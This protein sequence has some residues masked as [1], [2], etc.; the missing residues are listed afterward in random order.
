MIV[1]LQALI[2]L[3]ALYGA[4]VVTARLAFPLPRLSA[5]RKSE[6]IPMSEETTLGRL[7]AQGLADN[8][9]KSGVLGIPEGRGA[10]A[11]RLELARQA[12]ASIDAQY[13]IWEDDTSGRLLMKALFDAAQR[14]VRVRMLLDDN[15]T[16]GLDAV[17]AALDG[18]ENF[19]VRLFNPS[20]LRWPKGAGFV[21]DFVR[22]NRRMHNKAFIVDGAVAIVGGRNVADEYFQLADEGFFIDLDVLA[23]GAVAPETAAIFDLYWNCD[24]VHPAGPVIGRRDATLPGWLTG[25]E[26]IGP[27]AESL[28]MSEREGTAADRFL[29]GDTRLEWVNAQAIAD[30]PSKGLG[31]ASDGQLMITRLRAAAG[32]VTSGVDLVSAYFIPAVGGVRYFAELARKGA[33]VRILTNAFRTTDVKMVHAGYAKYR[34]RLLAAGVELLELKPGSDGD[35]VSRRRSG[36]GPSSGST[37][38]T[39]LHAKTLALDGNRVFVGSFNFDPRSARINCEMGFMIES[40]AMAERL[41]G[42]FDT[43]ATSTYR[44]ALEDGALCWRETAEDETET[45]HRTEPGASLADRLALGLLGRLPIEWLL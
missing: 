39:S 45:V 33:R 3:I 38:G 16:E 18:L 19:E 4:A 1:F 17:L 29:R 25:E 5:R 27:Q 30:H 22:M 8:P 10:I 11:S 21:V 6:A 20:R 41:T 36:S 34:R 32:A 40:P 35:A 7:V 28:A 44:V 13:Y 9:G 24:C 23:A 15:G 37:S 42:R 12:E 26:A 14:G 31:K 43:L 2:V